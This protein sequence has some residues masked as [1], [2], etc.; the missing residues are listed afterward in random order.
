MCNKPIYYKNMEIS[1]IW[2]NIFI[3]EYNFYIWC[4]Q[5]YTYNERYLGLERKQNG[6]RVPLI[7]L[8]TSFEFW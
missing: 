1:T 5:V 4:I 6:Y 3:Q 2:L 7:N 8:T